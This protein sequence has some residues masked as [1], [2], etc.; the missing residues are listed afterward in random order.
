MVITFP[1]MLSGLFAYTS[2][3]IP[4]N[5]IANSCLIFLLHLEVGNKMLLK[6]KI[7]LLGGIQV[8][9]EAKVK[10]RRI[11]LCVFCTKKRT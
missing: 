10:A 2:Y 6:I 9:P 7:Q 4:L 5:T 3:E 11:A 1:A 8:M